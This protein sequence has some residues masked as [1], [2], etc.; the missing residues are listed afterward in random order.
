MWGE[1]GGLLG[2]ADA[3]ALTPKAVNP[4]C[5]YRDQT[6]QGQIRFL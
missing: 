4:I 6:D 5:L 2:D 1:R 3:A